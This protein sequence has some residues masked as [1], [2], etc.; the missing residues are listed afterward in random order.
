[1][2]NK[3]EK[4]IIL[5]NNE[6]FSNI[7]LINIE[8]IWIEI[9]KFLK[10]NEIIKISKIS[11]TFQKLTNSEIIYKNLLY[12]EYK[13]ENLNENYQT[14][15]QQ[16]QY[17]H[18]KIGKYIGYGS[19]NYADIVY[20]V[21]LVIEERN[22][23]TQEFTGF[24][25]WSIAK[26]IGEFKIK[27]KIT[28]EKIYFEEYA[29]VNRNPYFCIGCEFNGTFFDNV[30]VAGNWTYKK[31]QLFGGFY[32]LKEYCYE[33]RKVSSLKLGQLNW[34]YY[35]TCQTPKIDFKI[36][37]KIFDFQNVLI[38]YN[39]EEKMLLKC[40][41][42]T[43]NFKNPTLPTFVFDNFLITFE[44]DFSQNIYFFK[45]FFKRI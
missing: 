25:K 26:N 1:M 33:E 32:T 6:K 13:I 11:K 9:I 8:E 18:S 34:Y 19:Q 45:F 36:E 17:H 27:G 22:L 30:L 24:T 38:N 2:G 29:M 41:D 3:N 40:T 20:R 4:E 44:Y 39:E 14:F 5:K 21:E 42:F 28:D 37:K 7:K 10:M 23:K 31:D 15:K 43:I 12:N 16:Y 35:E